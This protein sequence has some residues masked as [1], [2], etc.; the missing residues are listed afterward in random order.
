MW[1]VK[2]CEHYIFNVIRNEIIK[3]R[4]KYEETEKSNK[5]IENLKYI[6]M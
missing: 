1:L 6:N 3:F 2:Q 4:R 5:N